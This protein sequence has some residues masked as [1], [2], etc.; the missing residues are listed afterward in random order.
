M[1][2]DLLTMVG[3]TVTLWQATGE[4]IKGRLYYPDHDTWAV[5]H[6]AGRETFYSDQVSCIVL[7]EA[8]FLKQ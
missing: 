8:I 5:S 6:A 4:P 3:K 7:G 1:K 2:N